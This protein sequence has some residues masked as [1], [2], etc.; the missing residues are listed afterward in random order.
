MV[1]VNSISFALNKM[2]HSLRNFSHHVKLPF[3][4]YL[5]FP[6]LPF[7]PYFTSPILSYLKFLFSYC[8]AVNLR[9]V[10]HFIMVE[11]FQRF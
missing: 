5:Y 11:G 2:L 10:V 4:P 3:L 6:T 7:Q 8:F 9:K 1:S